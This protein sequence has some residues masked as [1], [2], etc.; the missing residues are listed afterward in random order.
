MTKF[1]DGSVGESVYFCLIHNNNA[2]CGSGNSTVMNAGEDLSKMILKL[3]ESISFDEN[4][5][6][7]QF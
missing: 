4:L 5:K 6:K 2:L 7:L 3:L 1:N